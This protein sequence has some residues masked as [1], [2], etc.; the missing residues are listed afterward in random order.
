M[1]ETK[2]LSFM[3]ASG[4]ITYNMTNNYMFR[5]ILQKNQSVLKGLIC[6]L[7]HLNPQK[8]KSIEI[9]N[10]INL[11]DNVVGKEFIL[12]INI[13]LNNDTRINL[14]MQ[15]ATNETGTTALSVIFADLLINCTKAKIMPWP[16]Q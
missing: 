3:K 1:T 13:M 6:S 11:S 2:E 7:L 9:V 5:Y 16:F 8:V 14:E 12:D 15:V 10:P 4:E